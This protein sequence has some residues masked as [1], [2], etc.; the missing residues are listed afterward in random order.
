MNAI[1]LTFA[2]AACHFASI[3]V[4]VDEDPEV[5]EVAVVDVELVDVL[6][7]VE[8][9]VDEV[10]EVDVD[11]VVEVDDVVD[12]EDDA[13]EDVVEDPGRHYMP[14]RSY[15]PGTNPRKH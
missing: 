14:V 4:E 1:C 10:V 13:V 6:V 9:D 3:G 2:Y 15:T 11:E 7:V 12:V 8:V 5:V